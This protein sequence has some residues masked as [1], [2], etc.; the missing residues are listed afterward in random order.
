MCR[1]Q[2]RHIRLI[3]FIA[4]LLLVLF[5]CLP[6]PAQPDDK[7]TRATEAERFLRER[8][9]VYF[10]FVMPATYSTSRF[11]GYLS[12]S[13][14]HADTVYAFAN[15]GEFR[16]FVSEGIPY[17]VLV[18]PSLTR[19]KRRFF[20]EQKSSL[21]NRYLTYQSMFQPY[22]SLQPLI[23]ESAGSGN[24]EPHPKDMACMY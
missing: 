18:P 2:N 6:L 19:P 23:L 20:T 9:E 13:S 12:I 7:S 8:G 11:S 10:S 14:I 4:A 3:R 16:Q 24:S 5:G 22:S 17:Q 21:Y 15:T 1:S